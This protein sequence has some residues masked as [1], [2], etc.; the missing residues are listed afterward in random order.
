MNKKMIWRFSG[1]EMTFEKIRIMGILN[2]TPDSFSD[3]GE[4]FSKR[5]AV[6][7]ALQMEEE[8]ADLIDIGGESTRPGAR[9]VSEE[10]ELERVLPVVTEL[11]LRTSLP[12]SI[13]TTKSRVAEACLHAGAHIINDVSGLDAFHAMA[14]L[15]RQFEAGLILMHRRG[16][17]ETMQRLAHY[18]D[19]VEEVFREL[20]QAFQE[21]GQT[22]LNPEQVVLDPGI[23]FSKTAPHNLEILNHLD[24]FHSW[25]RPI[26]VGPSRKSFIG[27]L[28]GK[29]PLHRDWGTAA[30]VALAAARGANILR[31]H[32]VAAMADVVKVAQS[33]I[34][35]GGPLHVRS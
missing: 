29:E 24:R 25:G 9:P 1:R 28:T 10:E 22:G 5:K 35:Q 30:A 13:D 31:V 18:D 33:I 21:T 20:D 23:G 14:P 7:R 16:T 27:N 11:C 34:E 26:L 17:P 6:E 32:H 2:V 4:F 8:G 12:I 15:A 19:V 3:G